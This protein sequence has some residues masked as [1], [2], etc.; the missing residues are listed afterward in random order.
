VGWKRGY[1]QIKGG[2]YSS[3]NSGFTARTG[4]GGGN[5]DVLFG[6]IEKFQTSS[7]VDNFS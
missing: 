7:K 3:V 1:N 2:G 6:N 4:G 5:W